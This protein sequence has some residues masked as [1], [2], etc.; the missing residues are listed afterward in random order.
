MHRLVV[1]LRCLALV[2]VAVRLSRT[3]AIVAFY[4]D[5]TLEILDLAGR[6]LRKRRVGSLEVDPQ[7]RLEVLDLLG[8]DRRFGIHVDVCR[9]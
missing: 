7:F 1:A 2:E 8:R 6:E 4:P 3:V 5:L 9:S